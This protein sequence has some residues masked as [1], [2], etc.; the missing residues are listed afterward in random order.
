MLK[1]ETFPSKHAPEI[2]EAVW[3]I[4]VGYDGSYHVEQ[5]GYVHTIEGKIAHCDLCLLSTHQFIVATLEGGV[6]ATTSHRNSKHVLE[7]LKELAVENRVQ[8]I[9]ALKRE[10]K[11]VKSQLEKINAIY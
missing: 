11:E 4:Q 6:E 10:M 8:K 1:T 2:N 9:R 7:K 5:M 3:R